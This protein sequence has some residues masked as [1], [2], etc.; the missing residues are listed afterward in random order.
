M[1][2]KYQIFISYRRD[3]GEDLARLLEYKLTD[4]GFKVFFDV[5]SLRSGD[6]NEALFEK[7][8]E[9][10]AV[11]VVLP[12]HGLDRCVDPRDWVRLEIARALELQKSDSNKKVIPI[13]MRNFE[14]PETLPDDIDDLRKQNAVRADHEYFDAT[15][16]KLISFLNIK[17]LD[18][19]KQLLKE[20]EAGNVLAMNA[21]GLRYEFGSESLQTKRR[22]AFFFYNKS[23]E[24]G[25]LGALYN[26]GDVYE[27]CEKDVSLVYDYGI[28]H[29]ALPQNADDAR[30]VLHN[31]AVECYT[32]AADMNFAPAIYRLANLA[33]DNNDFVKALKLY[34]T[35]AELN[36]PAAQNALGYYKMN[37]IE[38]NR[39]HN[40]AI[41]LYKRA[42]DAEYEP[43]IYN[44]AHAMKSKNPDEAIRYY[45]KIAYVI[46]KAAFSLAK[47]YEGT[48]H[49]LQDAADYYR[50]A[51]EAGIQEAGDGLK[52][53]QDVFFGKE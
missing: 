41:T 7:I 3:G 24:A 26:L 6:F 45:K 4:R 53:C 20:A 37:G 51:Y 18:D 47:L 2:T 29:T 15:I 42:A 28:D 32:K 30:K 14:F 16:D 52:R 22:E 25:N 31:L 19:D 10:T 35:A 48:L 50:M 23:A 5:E 46:P 38:T 27:Q 40:S 43:A 44:Y 13:M 21:I 12:P 49:Q 39:D 1:Q 36:Y 33:E 17:P 9:C 8:A 11:L 34:Q